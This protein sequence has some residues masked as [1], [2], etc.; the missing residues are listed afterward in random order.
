MGL[1][2]PKSYISRLYQNKELIDYL[3]T[4]RDKAVS[5]ED[6]YES[7]ILDRQEE[8]EEVLAQLEREALVLSMDGT[9]YLDFQIR[10]HLEEKLGAYRRFGASHNYILDV[11]DELKEE[12]AFFVDCNEKEK[13]EKYPKLVVQVLKIRGQIESHTDL[14]SQNR[15]Y[16]TTIENPKEKFARLRKFNAYL[17]QVLKLLSQLLWFLDHDMDSILRYQHEQRQLM[18][19]FI[20]QAKRSIGVA[21]RATAVIN[22]D[23]IEYIHRYVKD[24]AFYRKAKRIYNYFKDG[25][26]MSETDM[27]S[28][29][30]SF[31][32][33]VS[34]F[35]IRRRMDPENIAENVFVDDIMMRVAKQLGNRRDEETSEDDIP[36]GDGVPE[37]EALARVMAA[38]IWDSFLDYASREAD[39]DLCGFIFSLSFSEPVTETE[40][41]ALASEIIDAH[42]DDLSIEDRRGTRRAFSYVYECEYEFDYPIITLKV[43]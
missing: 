28:L 10:T 8:P 31:V 22:D 35:R 24:A 21:Q 19:S 25:T 14:L 5:L 18:V 16:I 23:I 33:R 43:S 26:L 27:D 40:S 42:L 4:Y 6:I 37:T 36:A 30:D 2:S 32:D 13:F 11:L 20:R 3:Y 9:W 17:D 38:E 41:I 15:D 39:V 29:V 12:V 7:G 1:I 34:P